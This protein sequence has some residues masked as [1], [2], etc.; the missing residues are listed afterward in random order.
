VPDVVV[1]ATD[2][3]Y[4]EEILK[5]GDSLSDAVGFNDKLHFI[6]STEGKIVTMSFLLSPPN[7]STSTAYASANRK[8]VTIGADSIEGE[9]A[10]E[11]ADFEK[12]S[13]RVKFKS[14][15]LKE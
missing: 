14:A 10:E 9:L 4:S 2:R 8:S 3:P 5:K 13:Y 12:W 1:L 7:L 15:I 6:I 11:G